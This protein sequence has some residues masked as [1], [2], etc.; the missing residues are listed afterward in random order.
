MAQ[1]ENNREFLI[2]HTQWD[3]AQVNSPAD[4]VITYDV[5]QSYFNL[6]R[7][8]VSYSRKTHL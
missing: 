3:Q 6:N 7:L 5:I 1:Q 4:D 2:T 8:T